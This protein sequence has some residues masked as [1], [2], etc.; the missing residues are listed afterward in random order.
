M[1][2][3]TLMG[4]LA[5]DDATLAREIGVAAT[6]VYRTRTHRTKPTGSVLAALNDWARSHGVD[7]DWSHLRRPGRK[8]GQRR[9]RRK[10]RG[11]R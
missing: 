2:L 5:V 11:R 9:P 10:P 7:L 3:N 1:Q 4:Q 6:T 8:G